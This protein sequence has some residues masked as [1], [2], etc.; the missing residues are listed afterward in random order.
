M[1]SL[2]FVRFTQFI[3]M[4]SE[5]INPSNCLI[6]NHF[7]VVNIYYFQEEDFKLPTL[8]YLSHELTNNQYCDDVLT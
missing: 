6:N 1:T 8:N 5:V 4:H 2:S 3:M 7:S